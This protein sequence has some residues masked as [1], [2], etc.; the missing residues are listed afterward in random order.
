MPQRVRA[1]SVRGHVVA[2]V[3]ALWVA[4]TGL[5][6][7]AAAQD[8]VSPS[9]P[10][11]VSPSI[12]DGASAAAPESADG[13]PDVALV[14]HGDGR[15][16]VVEVGADD[17]LTAAGADGPEVLAVATD[18][19]ITGAQVAVPTPDPV[20]SVQYH[21]DVI[22]A[23]ALWPVGTGRGSVIAVIDSGVRE[24][25]VDFSGRL[26]PGACF[27]GAG[28]NPCAEPG[29][30][31]SPLHPHGTHVAGIAAAGAGDG[32]GVVGVA[33][34]AE[35]L[36]VRVLDEN[37]S[38][39]LSDLAAGVLHA[40]QVDLD[41]DGLTPDV[42]V[43]NLSIQSQSSNAVVAGAIE[44][45]IAAGV[46]VV[47]SAGNLAGV[48]NPTVFPAAEPGVIGVGSIGPGV[49]GFTRAPTS[50][51]G[52]W[53]DL[54]APGVD[55]WSAG[56]DNDSD[57][58]LRSGTSMSAPQVSGAVA[59]LLGADPTLTVEQV[60]GLLR[61]SA[62]DLGPVGPD[63]EYGA[64]LLD[65]GA[66]AAASSAQP[67]PV[68]L[69]ATPAAGLVSLSWGG[70]PDGTTAWLVE[71]DGAVQAVLPADATTADLAT[72]V[73]APAVYGVHPI[74]HYVRVEGAVSDPVA[75]LLPPGPPT[76]LVVE[77]GPARLELRWE[78]PVE[79][80]GG[81]SLDYVV[82]VR[83]DGV[84]VRELETPTTVA[85]LR[86]LPPRGVYEIEV[87]ARTEVG[88]GAAA[89]ASAETL[90]LAPPGEPEVRTV[91]VAGEAL[92]LDWEPVVGPAEFYDVISPAGLIERL[93]GDVT[94]W[95]GPL[96]EDRPA[97][98]IA[99]VAV[100][101]L[102]S[103]RSQWQQIPDLPGEVGDLAAAPSGGSLLV[104]WTPPVGDPVATGYV[105][106]WGPPGTITDR[107]WVTEPSIVIRPDDVV[108]PIEIV[109][110][111]RTELAVGW[112]TSVGVPPLF[113]A[114][115]PASGLTAV[116]GGP[117]S[118]GVELRWR[119]GGG[120]VDLVIVERRVADGAWRPIV[121]L[122]NDDREAVD[123][124]AAVGLPNSYRIRSV[125]PGGEAVSETFT[126]LVPVPITEPLDLTAASGRPAALELTW[127]E[128][129]SGP[130]DGY[131]VT[132]RDRGTV[133]TN[134]LSSDPSLV[135]DDLPTGVTLSVEV[136]ALDEGRSGPAA[137]IAVDVPPPGYWLVTSSGELLSFG[138]A[139]AIID[140]RTL[141]A[142]S[143][144]LAEGVR[145]VD[146]T[147][148][149]SAGGVAV[150]LADGTVVSAGDVAV[151]SVGDGTLD[152]GETAA[153]M[154]LTPSSAGAWLVT[155]RGRVIVRGDAG[156]FGDLAGTGLNGLIVGITP[157]PT[158]RGYR[159]AAADGGV[160]AFGDATFHGSM[161]GQALNAAVVGIASTPSGAG[162]VLAAADGGVFAFGDAVF[163]GS[164]GGQ[165]LNAAVVGIVSS[166][167][168][169]LLAAAD[170]GVFAF[171][172]DAVFA[173]S[174][175]GR[176]L[177]APVVGIV[178][179]RA[180][181]GSGSESVSGDGPD[182]GIQTHAEV[183]ARDL[184]VL[185]FG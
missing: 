98:L 27:L 76:N 34:A 93:P 77:P 109:V 37:N 144:G 69:T 83:L 20:R 143:T 53:V 115:T 158:G 120:D 23:E 134:R 113:E 159:L 61:T 141:D 157:T 122:S 153:A 75:P 182:V 31:P 14:R 128:P 38:G 135:L 68:V 86:D 94:I 132:V 168:G 51:F 90:G 26:L 116:L 2:V 146:A 164:M 137:S 85:A 6:G 17:E 121:L 55:I 66:L 124:R 16:E 4:M 101:D 171:G 136:R 142:T 118:G 25:H 185:D 29:Q 3:V 154:A 167:T 24:T 177:D 111:A 92:V 11:G 63:P 47:A 129:L 32:L 81:S 110:R 74:V 103:V 148:T 49:G 82:R 133:V 72:S 160:F 161:G 1:M 165:A 123:R 45:A 107:E 41:G 22:E 88:E 10:D 5:T 84:V 21:L 147:S 155:D 114:P 126:L 70:G 56:L 95:E 172:P 127:A 117:V 162:Y 60:T 170:G 9:I 181:G 65:L 174:Q 36:P 108:A 78:P 67:D 183:T 97:R 178:G 87:F 64:G 150:L 176:P 15:L 139:T 140:A 40:L 131:E 138:G 112:P 180:P 80:G 43:I 18:G 102:G 7:I 13:A 46:P 179:R 91:V 73:L 54:V 130:P 166:G 106:E 104:S 50:S 52:P 149:A 119:P 58:S 163:H 156:F 62:S 184:D 44:Q 12:P 39:F 169:Y 151:A 30:G 79:V 19:P 71:V 145:V 99:V 57:V 152:D 48:G 8:L 125:G 59:A 173:G 33:P 175:G 105:V 35:V 28:G 100:N 89:T 42:D 96:S